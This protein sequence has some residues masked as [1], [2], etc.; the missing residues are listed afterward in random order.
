[1]G[2]TIPEEDWEQLGL[3][4]CPECGRPMKA[5]ELNLWEHCRECENDRLSATLKSG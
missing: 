4:K 2:G 1:M 3:W 5:G